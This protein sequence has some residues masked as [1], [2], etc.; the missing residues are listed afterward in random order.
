[1]HRSPG[2]RRREEDACRDGGWCVTV[3][4]LAWST[5][6]CTFPTFSAREEREDVC[7]GL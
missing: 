2:I 3:W 5:P 1:M 6:V 7:R 4:A